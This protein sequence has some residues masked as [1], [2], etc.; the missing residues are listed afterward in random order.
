MTEE[1][2]G[3]DSQVLLLI[4]G[5]HR[6]FGLSLVKCMATLVFV[7]SARLVDPLSAPEGVLTHLRSHSHPRLFFNSRLMR[8]R[9]ETSDLWDGLLRYAPLHTNPSRLRTEEGRDLRAGVEWR[10]VSYETAQRRAKSDEEFV[11]LD[12]S[13]SADFFL[14]H[15]SMAMTTIPSLPLGYTGAFT[16]FPPSSLWTVSEHRDGFKF[17]KA[18]GDELAGASDGSDCASVVDGR[19]PSRPSVRVQTNPLAAGAAE[20]FALQDGRVLLLPLRCL[21]DP[22][23][24]FGIGDRGCESVVTLPCSDLTLC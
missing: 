17:P 21:A 3:F 8:K 16:K 19:R 4:P 23:H 18:P 2:S 5:L 12:D 1:E 10:Q 7:A 15:C 20:E 11:F 22:A 13:S 24:C 6:R 14:R 9:L